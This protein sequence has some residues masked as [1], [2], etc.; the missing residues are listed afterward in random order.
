MTPPHVC[1]AVDTVSFM[2]LAGQH[3]VVARR[4]PR[5][6]P[7]LLGFVETRPSAPILPVGT[8]LNGCPGSWWA[9]DTGLVLTHCLA[10]CAWLRVLGV[11]RPAPCAPD[12]WTPRT[13]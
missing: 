6:Q 1:E 12:T 11:C 10:S 3:A 4:P 2:V 7:C 5:F 13:F 9:L 8:Q